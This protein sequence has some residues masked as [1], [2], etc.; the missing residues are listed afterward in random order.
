MLLWARESI[1]MSIE[2]AAQAADVDAARLAGWEHE[3]Q[4]DRPTIAQVRKLAVA[5]RRPLAAFFLPEP[6]REQQ[7]VADFRRL[8]GSPRDPSPELIVE[9]RT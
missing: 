3:P 7:L 9:L 4:V 5:Y 6:P 2:E 8:P 1:G